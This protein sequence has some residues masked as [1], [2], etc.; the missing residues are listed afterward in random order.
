MKKLIILVVAMILTISTTI[1]V[2]AAEDEVVEEKEKSVFETDLSVCKEGELSVYRYGIREEIN[3]E[4]TDCDCIGL[5][6]CTQL[7]HIL[8]DTTEDDFYTAFFNQNYWDR[9]GKIYIDSSYSMERTFCYEKSIIMENLSHF[10]NE[11]EQEIEYVYINQ[12]TNLYEILSSCSNDDFGETLD[13]ISVN[14]LAETPIIITDLWNTAGNEESFNIMGNIIFCVPYAST[15]KEGVLH[16]EE[17][18]NNL[19][20]NY[21]FVPASLAIYVIYTDEVIVEYSNGYR[22]SDEGCVTIYVP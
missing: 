7:Y 6:Q 18:V 8:E 11:K 16:C 4:L 15:D 1:P 14:C 2:M 22:N 5:C 20:S 19:L 12:K 3:G 13:G 17:V 21:S 10:L 9:Y